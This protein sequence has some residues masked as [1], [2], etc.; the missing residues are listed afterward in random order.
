MARSSGCNKIV[1][2][3]WLDPSRKEKTMAQR[4]KIDCRKYPSD[5]ACT[6]V[7]SGALEEVVELGWLHAK[8]HHAHKD[9]E[10]KD[11]KQWIR[12]NAESSND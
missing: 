5:Q 7:I 12:T 3:D 6:V 10:E 11:L 1:A 2:K 9:E 8:M 4:F